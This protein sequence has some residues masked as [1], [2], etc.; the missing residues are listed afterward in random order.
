MVNV[1]VLQP[2]IALEPSEVDLLSTRFEQACALAAAEAGA[3]RLPLASRARLA[4]I[5]ITLTKMK[6]LATPEIQI[7]AVALF[8]S[9]NA[10]SMSNAL[11]ATSNAVPRMRGQL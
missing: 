1:R 9:E 11:A 8:R 2:N 10:V 3:P 4:K 6:K 5:M 7:L